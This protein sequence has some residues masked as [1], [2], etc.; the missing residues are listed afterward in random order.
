[1]PRRKSLSF[2]KPQ[3]IQIIGGA[4]PAEVIAAAT[5]IPA[6]P[7]I[8]ALSSTINLLN[9]NPYLIAVFYLFLNLGGRYLSLE[10]TKRQEWV[11]SQPLLRPFILFTVMFI[12]TRN[13]AVAFWTTIGILS[14]LWVFA[15]ENSDFCLIPGWKEGAKTPNNYEDIMGKL[16]KMMK[17]YETH[18]D[19][20]VDKPDEDEHG[21][22]EQHANDEQHGDDDLNDDLN[23]DTSKP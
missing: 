12:S 2:I 15:N 3:V 20:H 6:L 21:D 22:G 14:V 8:D 23:D 13:I 9:S 18:D 7:Q 5:N 17:P 1:M 16:K 11:L 4:A 10:L 19:G